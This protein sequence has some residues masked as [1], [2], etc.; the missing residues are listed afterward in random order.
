M[1]VDTHLK[2]VA[3]N[4]KSRRLNL[5]LSQMFMASKLSITQNAYCK[6]EMSKSKMSVARLYEIAELL[7]ISPLQLIDTRAL[8]AITS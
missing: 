5:N 8:H 4:I 6:I 7:G 2:A 3:D 1:K